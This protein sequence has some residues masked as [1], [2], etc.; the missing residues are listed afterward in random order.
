M[1]SCEEWAL[2]IDALIH[3]VN[4]LV[5]G[6]KSAYPFFDYHDIWVY[7]ATIGDR[8]PGSVSNRGI[9]KNRFQDKCSYPGVRFFDAKDCDNYAGYAS[10]DP[11]TYI[12]WRNPPDIPTPGS[13]KVTDVLVNA[14]Y[15]INM[16]I[17][18]AH[19]KTGVTLSFKNH[20][21]SLA[22]VAPLHW[23]ISSTENP[24]Y[25]GGT[26]YNPMVDI[27]RNP[28]IAN[29]TVLTI[30]DGLYGNWDDNRTKPLRW[31]T[32]NDD[33][34]NSLF[35]STDPVA[36]DSVM[37]DLVDAEEPL[38]GPYAMARDVLIYAESVG[39]GVFEHGDPWR[40]PWG[41]GYSKIEYKRIEIEPGRSRDRLFRIPRGIG[42]R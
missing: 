19:I 34:P 35:F 10:S 5:R 36:I 30:G 1:T 2:A 17:M 27:Y 15:V 9:P 22:N 23:W 3:P 28:H 42:G 24:P 33:A 14:T 12:T 11:T 39:L 32:F 41:S 21:G 38:T 40:Q 13:Q 26:R 7:D 25:Y 31:S 6:L 4:A 37:T 8:G 20:F 18:K 16:P 29:K